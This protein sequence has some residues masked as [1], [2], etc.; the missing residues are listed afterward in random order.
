MFG[1]QFNTLDGKKST[2]EESLRIFNTTIPTKLGILAYSLS[3]FLPWVGKLPTKRNQLYRDLSESAR[4]MLEGVMIDQNSDHNG[5]AQIH[6]KSIVELFGELFQLPAC[7]SQ[8]SDGYAQLKRL[9]MMA[10]TYNL[11]RGRKKS[12]PR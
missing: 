7:R 11:Q 6:D 10:P 1:Y 4:V 5:D 8:L 2:V 9:K 12:S 3:M